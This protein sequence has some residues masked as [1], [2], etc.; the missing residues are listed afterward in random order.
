MIKE[1]QQLLNRLNMFSDGIL[2]YLM[3]PLAYWLRF[4]ILPDGI[5]TV[6][7]ENYL[8]L[9]IVF[10]LIQLFTYAAFGVYQTSRKTRIRD[11]AATLLRANLLDMLLLLGV[12]PKRVT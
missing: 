12:L 8:R 6:P 2:S 1:N 5:Q 3:L 9:G 10:V 7:L 4:Y 11:E